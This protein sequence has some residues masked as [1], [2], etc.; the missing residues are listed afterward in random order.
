MH[1]WCGTHSIDLTFFMNHQ[2]ISV[3]FHFGDDHFQFQSGFSSA[4]SQ[5]ALDI[6]VSIARASEDRKALVHINGALHHGLI[7]QH[8]AHGFT[9]SIGHSFV[10]QTN[11]VPPAAP[12]GI[13]EVSP[14]LDHFINLLIEENPESF[15]FNKG[16][17]KITMDFKF[18]DTE[19]SLLSFIVS[20]KVP[21]AW[22][23]ARAMARAS[24]WLQCGTIIHQHLGLYLCLKSRV[25]YVLVCVICQYL[26]CI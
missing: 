10:S 16:L 5:I 22:A 13:T 1:T 18:G 24:G 17:W 12:V 7:I 8:V 23:K 9:V 4:D 26:D 19:V 6:A 14:D 15:A 25:C 2:V 11:E 20:H 3:A 21:G